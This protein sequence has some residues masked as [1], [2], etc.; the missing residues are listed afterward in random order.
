MKTPRDETLEEIW[1]IRRELAKRFNYDPK[2]AAA[3]YRR[4]Q[5]ERG[6]KIYQPDVSVGTDVHAYVL[7]DQAHT[8]IAA[9]R[10]TILTSYLASRK[11]KV[12]R[13]K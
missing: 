7:R 6:A 13:A 3:Y 11:R 1:T 2:K 8:R 10:S 12:K 9:G 4:K 5:K